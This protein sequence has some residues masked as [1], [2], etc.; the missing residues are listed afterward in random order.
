[1]REIRGV[2][3]LVLAAAALAQGCGESI[4]QEPASRYEL[5]GRVVGVSRDAGTVTIEHE[6]ILGFMAAMTMP[7]NVREAWVFE[8]VEE[9]ASVRATLVV[10][11]TSSWL[12]DV[13]VSKA[14]ASGAMADMAVDKPDPG[15]LLPTVGLTDQDNDEFTF[16]D[17]R[18]RWLA[19]TFIYTRCPLPDFCPRMSEQFQT[20]HRAIAG[21]RQRYGEALLLSIT[22]DPAFDTPSVLREYGRRYLPDADFGGWRFARVEPDD[23]LVLARFAGLHAMPDGNEVVHNLR[24][25]L[26]DPQGRVVTTLVGN[27]WT[28]DEL[29]AAL[30]A[31]VAER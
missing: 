17:L 26:V 15:S 7:F 1:M 21:D 4:P 28:P 14:A 22:V 31:A 30:A 9:G 13:V 8:A 23:L 3:A 25:L 20:V 2:A 18:G 29:L 24:T 5:N 27:T 16:E 11:G 19:L 6:E 12:E 10:Q